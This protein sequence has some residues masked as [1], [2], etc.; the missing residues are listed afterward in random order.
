MYVHNFVSLT[1]FFMYPRPPMC[2]LRRTCATLNRLNC[3]N[4]FYRL[5]LLDTLV[6]T[7]F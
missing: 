3:C 1:L 6:K 7:D 5:R 4:M 2:I